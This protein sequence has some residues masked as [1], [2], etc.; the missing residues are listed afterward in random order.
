M[1]TQNSDSGLILQLLLFQRSLSGNS[2]KLLFFQGNSSAKKLKSHEFFSWQ[3][4]R[5]FFVKLTSPALRA[6]VTTCRVQ[7]AVYRAIVSGRIIHYWQSFTG[8]HL[9]TKNTVSKR[10]V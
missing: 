5:R 9:G 3:G 7:M 1:G 8:R 2:E 6:E 4:F 10:M